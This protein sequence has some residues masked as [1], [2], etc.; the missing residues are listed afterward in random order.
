VEIIGTHFMDIGFA[1]VL[2]TGNLTVM[3][4]RVTKFN[5]MYLTKD[6]PG[7][8]RR[9]SEFHHSKAD[10]IMRYE[11]TY[12]LDGLDTSSPADVSFCCEHVAAD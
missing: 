7:Y 9:S 2:S 4:L 6:L 3:L 5:K 11:F 12:A 10:G 8:R 1:D